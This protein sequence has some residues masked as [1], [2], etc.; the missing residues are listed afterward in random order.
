MEVDSENG[1]YVASAPFESLTGTLVSPEKYNSIK[2]EVI[3]DKG[4]SVYSDEITPA[5][6]WSFEKPGLL[7]IVNTVKV[8]A[9]DGDKVVEDSILLEDKSALNI[10]DIKDYEKDTDGD[11]LEDFLEKYLGTD[12]NKVD[13]DGDGLTD[14]QEVVDLGL[15][16]LN[17]DT[18]GNGVSDYD[19]DNDSDTISN[20]QEYVL[21]TNPVYN[22]SDY[23]GLLDN[24]EINTYKTDPLNKDT[25][26]DGGEDKW[27]IDNG[28]DPLVA[29]E[30][31]TVTTETEAISEANPVSA[32]VSLDLK[33]GDVNSLSIEKAK[34]EDNAY[35]SYS[36]PGSL[37][38]AYNFS[39]DGKFDEAD[40]T[41]NYDTSLGTI[42]DNFQ[43]RIYYFNPETDELEELP[44]QTVENGKVTAKTTHFS[45]YILLNKVEYEGVWEQDFI[46]PTEDAGAVNNKMNVAFVIDRSASMDDN[47][48]T[49]IRL[50]LTNGFIDK[51]DFTKDQASVI[52]Y[53]ASAEDVQA[54]TNDIDALHNAVNGITNDDGWG[55][56]SG[57]NGSDGIKHGLDSIE[58]TDAQYKY[59]IFLT[60]GDDNRYS[61]SYSALEDEAVN[62][63][64]KIFTIGLGS[65]INPSQLQEIADKTGGKYYHAE[66]ADDL[67]DIYKD[68]ETATVDYTTDSNNDG[69][70]DYYTK[71]ICDG[72]LRLSNGSDE[73]SFFDYDEFQKNDDYDGDGIKNGDE[74]SVTVN[75]SG[76]AVL[77]M[78]SNFL[79]ADTDGDGITDD[80]EYKNGTDP[81]SYDVNGSA[82][83][84]LTD[85]SNYKYEE[86]ADE[87]MNGGAYNIRTKVCAAIFGVWDKDKIYRDIILSYYSDYVTNDTTATN[88]AEQEK[89]LTINL[90]KQKLGNVSLALL[91]MPNDVKN[92]LD[93]TGLGR[94]K[95]VKEQGKSLVTAIKKLSDKSYQDPDEYISVMLSKDLLSTDA[96]LA[97]YQ[98]IIPEDSPKLI[99]S[100]SLE[101]TPISKTACATI[102]KSEVS[103]KFGKAMSI[104][105][106]VATIAEDIHN[107]SKVNQNNEIFSENIDVLQN[108]ID[109]SQDKYH[110]KDAAKQVM[111]MLSSSFSDKAYAVLTSVLSDI[112]TIGIKA[113][114]DAIADAIPVVG[115][116]KAVIDSIDLLF[117]ISDTVKETYQMLCYHEMAAGYNNLFARET[118]QDAAG[119]VKIIGSYSL[120][121]RYISNIAQ[122]RILGEKTYYEHEKLEGFVGWIADKANANESAQKDIGARIDKINGH[123]NTLSLILVSKLKKDLTDDDIPI[124]VMCTGW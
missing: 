43:P 114:I 78:K 1:A 20:G 80:V 51:M 56:N 106:D 74:V 2:L 42:G 119:F 111:D 96:V 26:G 12:I 79:Y 23:D 76:N 104:V 4:T 60:D 109:T 64:I 87:F 82:V 68:T 98:V 18:D 15:D 67:P 118:D 115:A 93:D 54:L 50:S 107:V 45:T 83:N 52:S 86:K 117:G 103:S 31:F 47:D 100:A 13:T 19:E 75:K 22:D 77:N 28:Y 10:E 71:K 81:L 62:N 95:A 58:G 72:E 99:L 89:K 69:I 41:F 121:T 122:I 3:S 70:S 14:Y 40:L 33:D 35:I 57:T 101:T 16:P 113:A 97:D 44:N 36:I 29:N 55:W 30:S 8:S 21:G 84:Y 24:E 46:K 108:I 102:N 32:S 112:A 49:G 48:P 116:I 65:N 110:V 59:V 53:I 17:K 34:P 61:Y 9:K 66:K 7:P 88:I 91:K 38:G 6:S 39:V 37:G 94:L 85:D 123:T 120:Y 105:A 5:D 90:L 27:E 11:G 25:D 124:S 63:K 73:L 92:N